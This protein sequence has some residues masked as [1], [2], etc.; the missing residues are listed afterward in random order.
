MR[1]QELRNKY[2]EFFREKNHAIIPSAP[3]VPA[4]DPTTLFIIAGMHPLVPYLLGEKHPAGRR[5]ANVQKCIRTI[6]IDEVGDDTHVTFL[7]MLGN[8]SLGDPASPDGVG[9]GGYFKKEA[10]EWSFEFLTGKKWLNLDARRLAVSVFAGDEDAPRDQEAAAIW[11]ALGVADARIAY[12]PKADNW[13]GPAGQT[14]PCGPSTEMFYWIDAGTPAPANFQKTSKDPRWVEIWNDVFMEYNRRTNP[15][16]ADGAGQARRG[17]PEFVF[18]PLKQKNVDTGM[19]LDR[20]LAVLNGQRS[21][22][23][24]ELFKPMFDVLALSQEV[25]S[26]QE[27]KYAR[28]I[29]DHLRASVFIAADGVEPSNKDRGYVLRRL[30]RRSIVYARLLGL[31]PHWLPALVGKVIQIYDSAYPELVENSKKIFETLALEEEKFVSTL[32]RGLKEFEK[33]TKQG[34]ITGQTAFDLYQTYGFPLELTQELAQSAGQK[35][36]REQFERQFKKHQ[37]LSRTA[38]AGVFKGGL[39][40]HTQEVIRLHT[41]THLMNAALRKVLGE[42]VWQKGSNI[43]QERTRFDFTHGQKMTEEEKKRVEDL[44]NGW[45]HGDYQVKQEI[46]PLARARELG[47]LGV[48]GEKYADAVSVYTIFNP[49]TDEVI[50]REFCGGPHVPHTGV[51][52]LFKITKEQAIS[53]GVRRIKAVLS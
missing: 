43:T 13:W 33:K 8:W 50:S 26:N 7:E 15:P 28:V 17:E 53:A 40:D 42:H 6:D 39:A 5:L 49:K 10:I 24:T 2:L 41:A 9:Q 11:R 23:D 25:M 27:V 19:G 34:T 21:V 36:A 4:N 47:A 35:I 38:S 44:V 31:K 22:Y 1:A 29:V 30:L 37:E 45:I 20:M 14:G 46:L 16:Q 12:L 32:G 3:L 51:I 18:E 52:G 48:F